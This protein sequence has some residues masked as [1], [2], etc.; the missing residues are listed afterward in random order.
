MT[1]KEMQDAIVRTLGFENEWTIL[2][3]DLCEKLKPDEIEKVYL[4]IMTC[5]LLLSE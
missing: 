4:A 2:F 1:I 3:F 5:R